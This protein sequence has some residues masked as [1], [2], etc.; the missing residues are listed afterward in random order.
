MLSLQSFGYGHRTFLG[1]CSYKESPV[2]GERL[3]RFNAS[4][5]KPSQ[6]V[7]VSALM[8]LHS[9]PHSSLTTIYNYVLSLNDANDSVSFVLKRVG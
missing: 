3:P 4:L 7:L 6:P 1:A 5:E 8:E 2:G 9:F